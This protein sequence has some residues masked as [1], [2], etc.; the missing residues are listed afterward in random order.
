MDTIEIVKKDD[1]CGCASC[2]QRCPR[3]AI[4]ML[5]NEEG[6]LYPNIDK[7]KCVNCGL[8]S[9]VCPQLKNMKKN[10]NGYPKAYAMRNKNS[11][12]LL[13]SSSG[14]IFSVIADFVLEN[15]G[16]VFGATYDKNLNVNHVIAENQEDLEQLRGSKYVQS[17]IGETYKETENL[18]KKDRI[19]FFTGTPCQIAGLHSFLM[20]EYEN[21]ITCDLICHGVPSQK[22]F[23]MYIKYLSK[24][25][26]S[27]VIRYNF[28]AKGKN[29]WGLSGRV[30]TENGKIKYIKPDFDPYYSNFLE[31]T[32]YRKNCYKCHYANCN[33]VADITLAD[34]WGISGI[35]PDFYKEDG[36]SLIL[37]N[38][39]K[40]E[41]ILEKISSK[42]E[43]IQTDLYKAACHNKNLV[44][45][46]KYQNE[47]KNIYDGICEK[48]PEKFI[49]EN[50]K[51]K[52]T[53]KK[54][55]KAIIPDRIQKKL[56]KMRGL[57]K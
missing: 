2:V 52:L 55:L 12:V 34:Y 27:R 18:L 26:N 6:F 39:L 20:K 56:K 47:R 24:K 28:R 37:I 19:V 46:S 54:I 44:Q 10:S 31:G 8:C 30:E 25:L 15:N 9:R 43:Y 36:N 1:C 32:I 50:L 42:I 35:H 48:N 57:V 33:R 53:W 11:D 14:G 13:K 38:S 17:N 21:L 5:E 29:G 41:M 40:G 23:Q 3:Q 7:E 22:L 4:S 49:K 16:V 45:P 51:V